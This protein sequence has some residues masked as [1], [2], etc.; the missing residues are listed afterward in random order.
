MRKLCS[1]ILLKFAHEQVV[2]NGIVFSR[3]NG[4]IIQCLI[5]YLMN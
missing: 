5:A 3:S 1:T 4:L 2:N